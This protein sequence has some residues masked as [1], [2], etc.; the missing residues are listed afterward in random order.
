MTT[1][2]ARPIGPDVLKE[3]RT[4][5]DAGR[6]CV[7][8]TATEGGE[9]LRCCLRGAGPGE[10][11]ALVSYAPLRR[12]AAGTGARPGA[13]DEQGPVFIHA[14]ECGGPAADRAGYPFSRAGALRAVRRYNAAGEIVGG[15]LLEIP[16]DEERGYDEALAEAFAD[17]EVALVHVRAVEYGCLH[18]EVRRD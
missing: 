7:P 10:R 15:R 13:Y 4:S 6:P 2:E 3:L 18:F 5:D 11:I 16:A 12:W 8:Y 17:P 9:P 14:G 1:Y